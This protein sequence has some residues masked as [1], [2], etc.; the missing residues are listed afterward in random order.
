MDH[1]REDRVQRVAMAIAVT[2]FEESKRAGEEWPDAF[3]DSGL[4]AAQSWDVYEGMAM[5]A[6]RC[7][8]AIQKG[9]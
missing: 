3:E 5:S 6:I 9:A 4:Y 1:L 7:W 8:Q 2:D